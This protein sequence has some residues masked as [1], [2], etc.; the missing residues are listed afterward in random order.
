VVGEGDQAILYSAG[1]HPYTI[2]LTTQAPDPRAAPVER[3]GLDLAII[4]LSSPI[5]IE[6]L[7]RREAAELMDAHLAGV[8]AAG[9]RFAAW[10]PVP[11]ESP[12]PDD[13]DRVL[14][15]GCLGIS[16]PAD[17]L[18]T[19]GALE[20][21]ELLLQRVSDREVPLFIHPGPSPGAPRPDPDATEPEWWI[22]LTHYVSEMQ[23]AWL[24]WAG[25]GRRAH[26]D[27]VVVFAMLAGGAP[28]LAGRLAS[29]EGPAVDLR[30]PLTFYD[31]SSFDTPA[32]DA[33][34][35]LVGESQLV[36][37]S[38]RPV[39][40]PIQTRRDAA[41]QENGAMLFSRCGLLASSDPM[42]LVGG[43]A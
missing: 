3:D 25:F 28:V 35:G 24:A 8:R 19:P 32:V 6:A 21:I 30:D 20:T 26:P 10:G 41:L 31:T 18:A 27:L 14:A 29:R 38:D 37:G 36:Y 13:V 43:P 39:I 34:A 23:A 2:D 17:A 42:T 22:P 11:L 4:A 33:M 1:E 16:V 7:P 15:R 40:E 5:G 12:D 9:S